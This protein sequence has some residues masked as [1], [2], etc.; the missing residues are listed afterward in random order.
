MAKKSIVTIEQKA[1]YADREHELFG[2]FKNGSLDPQT[3]LNGLQRLLEGDSGQYVIIDCDSDPFI[4][5]GWTVEEHRKG[6]QFQWDSAKVSLYLSKRQKGGK[7]ITGDDLRREPE[8]QPVL[9]ANVLDYLLAHPE[10]IPDE[11]KGKYIFF[12]GTIYRNRVGRLYV[13]DL[14]WNGDGWRWSYRWLDSV[15][16]SDNPAAIRAS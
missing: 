11:W 15:W 10:L 16:F 14:A 13:R 12:W 9:N 6:G 2:R 1:G 8:G 4:P 5:D 7:L 3:V